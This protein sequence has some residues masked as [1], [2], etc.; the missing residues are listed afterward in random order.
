MGDGNRKGD[1]EMVA[2]DGGDEEHAEEHGNMEADED[3]D[4]DAGKPQD[5]PGQKSEHAGKVHL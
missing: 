5:G 2:A 4:E 3:A 1:A